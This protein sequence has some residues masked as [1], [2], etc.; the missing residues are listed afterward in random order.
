MREFS[1]DSA[2]T[3]GVTNSWGSHSKMCAQNGGHVPCVLRH[4]SEAAA[5]TLG[6]LSLGSLWPC[7]EKSRL[8]PGGNQALGGGFSSSTSGS[9]TALF[10]APSPPASPQRGTAHASSPGLL[11]GGPS[12]LPALHLHW[13]I[14]SMFLSSNSLDPE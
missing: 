11:H 12:A 14:P 6:M 13:H 7:R 10:F 8:P 5:F 3:S 2:L 9:P 1:G 4:L